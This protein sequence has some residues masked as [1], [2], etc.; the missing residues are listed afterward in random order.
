MRGGM[1]KGS[2]KKKKTKV[3]YETLFSGEWFG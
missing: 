3:G 2:E 1:V